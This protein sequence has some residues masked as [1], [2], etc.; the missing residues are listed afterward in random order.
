MENIVIDYENVKLQFYQNLILSDLNIK[1]AKGSFVYLIGAVG[2][3]KSTFLKSLYADVPIYSGS[4]SILDYDLAKI[5]TKQIPYLR[6]EVGIVF[7]DFKLLIDRT[8][9]QNLEF[10]LKSTGWKNRSQIDL[11]IE[12]VLKNVGMENKSY[13]M[14]HELSGGEQQRASIARSLLNS[15]SIILAD[16]PTGNL[17]PATGT[18]IVELLHDISQN[19]TTV[20]MSTHNYQAVKKYSGKILKFEDGLMREVVLSN[21]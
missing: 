20:L 1:I 11:R 16:E 9:H 4:A 8:I 7:Q 15:P 5:K 17:D 13:K 21:K 6:R 19:G 18:K 3:G 10:V 14:P 12:E 2:S